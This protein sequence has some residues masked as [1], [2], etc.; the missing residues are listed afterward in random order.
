MK[1]RKQDIL[2]YYKANSIVKEVIDLLDNQTESSN[3]EVLYSFIRNNTYSKELLN[4][5]TDIDQMSEIILKFN[6]IDKSD[7]V[8]NLINKLETRKKQKRVR[9]LI[10]SAFSVASAIFLFSFILNYS[11]IEG[12]INPVNEIAK[13][14]EIPKLAAP[15]LVLDNGTKVDLIIN[16]SKVI[17]NNTTTTTIKGNKLEYS[18]NGNIH[19]VTINNTIIVPSEYIYTITLDDGTEITLNA[20]SELKYPV[21]FNGEK[22]EVFLKGEAFFNVKKNGKIFI[23]NT[24]DISV[25]VYGTSFNINTHSPETIETTLISGSIGITSLTKD[26]KEVIIKPN[27]LCSYSKIGN[28]TNIKDVDISK[29]IN[30]KSGYFNSTREPLESLIN[31]LSIWYGVEFTFANKSISK[32]KVSVINLERKLPIDEILPIIEKM[33]NIKIIKT[34]QGEYMIK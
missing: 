24:S 15:T 4:K 32:I 19:P 31:D 20:N 21:S 33:V 30:W 9:I 1:N 13:I 8:S 29:Y 26:S 7:N 27:Q 16:E 12:S 2:D 5:L 18:N 3:G 17:T 23:V 28:K 10:Y 6:H 11:L 22:R 25:K 14:T 34:K